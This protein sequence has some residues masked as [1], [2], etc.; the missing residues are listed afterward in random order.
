M[1]PYLLAFEREEMNRR[2]NERIQEAAHERLVRGLQ[3]QQPSLWARSR[4]ALA[5]VLISLGQKLKGQRQ[6]DIVIPA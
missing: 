3:A 4:E 5:Q 1:N 2:L 6:P